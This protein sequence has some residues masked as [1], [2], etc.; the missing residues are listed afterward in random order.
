LI[1]TNVPFIERFVVRVP[2]KLSEQLFAFP[3]SVNK[4]LVP[5]LLPVTEPPL[6]PLVHVPLNVVTF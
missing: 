1:P 2:V 3:V 6:A 4:M 5:F